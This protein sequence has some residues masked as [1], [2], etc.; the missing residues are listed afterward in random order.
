MSYAH[1]GQTSAEAS[2]AMRD[3]AERLRAAMV[4]EQLRYTGAT[5]AVHRLQD[6]LEQELGQTAG[7]RVALRLARWWAT[8]IKVVG[9]G[10]GRR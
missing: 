8:L 6:Q 10:E 1:L 2:A 4:D 7:G 9:R 3:G 5:L